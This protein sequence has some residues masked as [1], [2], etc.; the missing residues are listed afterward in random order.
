MTALVLG[1]LLSQYGNYNLRRWGRR[2]RP[3][4]ILE[5]A[6][7]GFD[8]R[9]HLYS[10]SLPAP[11]V[12]LSPQGI[13]TLVTR[14]QTGQVSVTGSRWRT[15]MTLGRALLIFAQEGLGNPSR[16]ALEQAA[17][18]EQWLQSS[19][20]DFKASVQPAVVFID[21]RVQLQITDPEVPVLEA[22][23]L[24]KWLRGAGK[25]ELIKTADYRAVEQLFD[26]AAAG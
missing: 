19:L 20:P 23:G 24:K 14:D 18:L 11:H 15:K 25:A 22:K 26:G 8:D 9:Y 21:E 17:K 10:W 4:Q 2:P 12:L 3:D 16:D 1:F 13:Y 6:L 7:K 5:T